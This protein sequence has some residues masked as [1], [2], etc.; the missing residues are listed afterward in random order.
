[1]TIC[2]GYAIILHNNRKDK[3]YTQT[4]TDNKIIESKVDLLQRINKLLELMNTMQDNMGIMA[5]RLVELEKKVGKTN[6]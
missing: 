2:V 1:M 3:M 5:K 6:E 4:Q